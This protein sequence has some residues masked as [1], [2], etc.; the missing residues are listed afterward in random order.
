MREILFRGKRLD[1][2]E[3][4]EGFYA[5]LYDSKGNVS[6]RIYSGYAESD[7]GEFYPE[8]FEVDP[9]TIG[10]CINRRDRNDKKLFQGDIV[11]MYF[12]YTE[13]ERGIAVVEDEHCVFMDDL[14]KMFPQDVYDFEVIGNVHDNKE[15]LNED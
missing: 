9:N 14:G 6:H 1:N 8:W 2:G 5:R 11:E 13:N 10:R 12:A 7:C 15:L 4:V 3:W